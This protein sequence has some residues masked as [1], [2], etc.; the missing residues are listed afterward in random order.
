MAR[1]A[2]L[3]K[4]KRITFVAVHA[5][6]AIVAFVYLKAIHALMTVVHAPAVITVFR[7]VTSKHQIAI[8]GIIGVVGVVG[9][10]AMGCDNPEM[11][12]CV[13]EGLELVEKRARGVVDLLKA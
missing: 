8:F 6:V 3:R 4:E 5:F 1:T 12:Y 2:V 7:G 10:F 11:W 9:I 13:E